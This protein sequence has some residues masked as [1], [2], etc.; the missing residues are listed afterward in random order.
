MH[1]VATAAAVFLLA[2]CGA[3]SAGTAAGVASLQAAQAEKARE[4]LDSV[5]AGLDAAAKASQDR[6]ER[7]A[8]DEK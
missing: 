2:G 4:T 6:L 3:E 8:E 5:K 7:S 1:V